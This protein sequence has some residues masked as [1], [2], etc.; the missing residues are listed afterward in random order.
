M[1]NSMDI[2]LPHF[3]THC[4]LLLHRYGPARGTRASR[5]RDTEPFQG[6]DGPGLQWGPNHWE[7]ISK[8][9][10][11]GP[12]QR[13]TDLS[14]GAEYHRQDVTSTPCWIEIHL[15][16]PL[17]WLDKVLTQMGSPSNHISSVS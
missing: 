12:S 4:L 13:P 9:K 6:E 2:N 15:H 8:E 10:G 1:G 17:Q 5:E 16:G 11:Q 3:P 7:E 14:R